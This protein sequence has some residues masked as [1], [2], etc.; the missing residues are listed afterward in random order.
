MIGRDWGSPR[1]RVFEPA[2]K[3]NLAP[4][5]PCVKYPDSTAGAGAA[6]EVQLPWHDAVI[7]RSSTPQHL[8]TLPVFFYHSVT[9][10]PATWQSSTSAFSQSTLSI[11]SNIRT[12]QKEQ[13][14][15]QLATVYTSLHIQTHPLFL[16]SSPIISSAATSGI[17]PPLS[18]SK[19]NTQSSSTDSISRNGGHG[20]PRRCQRHFQHQ[21]PQRQ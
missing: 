20:Q 4:Q 11:T 6:G 9:L 3:E 21:Y 14:S 13:S 17:D 18:A 15:R 5:R 10:S 8:A 1:V 19:H 16:S 2:D 12:K 7:S